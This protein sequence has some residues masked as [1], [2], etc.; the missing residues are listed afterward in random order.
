MISRLMTCLVFQLSSD[1][2]KPVATLFCGEYSLNS[3]TEDNITEQAFLPRNMWPPYA[4][5]L[6]LHE[7]VRSPF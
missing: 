5:Y 3:G 1:A 7:E 2:F 6:V 4:G